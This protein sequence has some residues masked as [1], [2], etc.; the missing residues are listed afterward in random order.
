MD[1]SRKSK[2][3]ITYLYAIPLAFGLGTFASQV[4]GQNGPAYPVTRSNAGG[5]STS[6]E[7]PAMMNRELSERVRAAL[8]AEPYFY[9]RHVDVTVEGDAVVLRGVVFSDWEL[10]DALRVARKAAGHRRVVDNLSLD[11]DFRR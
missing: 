2:G 11:R 10:Q 7:E 8:H 6:T 9:D 1:I 4:D 3:L 5:T